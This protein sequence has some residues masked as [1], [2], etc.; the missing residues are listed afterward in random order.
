MNISSNQTLEKVL[1]TASDRLYPEKMGK[2]KVSIDSR[3]SDG[4]T[5]LHVFIWGG[6]TKNALLLIDNGADLN[7]IGDM[8]ETPIHVAIHKKDMKVIQALLKA[9]VQTNII[10]EFQ[11]SALDLA[12]EEGINLSEIV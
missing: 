12:K 3:G 10:S 8:G 6:E 1:Q 7:A 4:D 2:A 9:G 5:A 11:K